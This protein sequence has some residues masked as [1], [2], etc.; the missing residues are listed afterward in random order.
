MRTTKISAAITLLLLTLS[1]GSAFAQPGK[2]VITCSQSALAAFKPLPKLEY[3][4]SAGPDESDDKTLKLPAR[5]TAVERLIKE[6]TTFTDVAWWSEKV[7]DLERCELRG[8]AGEL[9]DEEIDKWQRGD[10]RF[11]LFGN[12]RVRLVLVAD[13]YYQNGYND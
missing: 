13:P 6:L 8:R 12:N 3:E 7:Q 10:F 11:D 4:C 1:L 2:P 5:I 9:S